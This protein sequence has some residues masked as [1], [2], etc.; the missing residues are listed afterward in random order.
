MDSGKQNGLNNFPIGIRFIQC[1]EETSFME[2]HKFINLMLRYHMLVIDFLHL[3]LMNLLHIVRIL[4]SMIPSYSLKV[5]RT[6][7][8]PWKHKFFNLLCLN[9][10]LSSLLF[11]SHLLSL[12]FLSLHWRCLFLLFVHIPCVPL[13]MVYFEKIA[14]VFRLRYLFWLL[15]NQIVSV[16]YLHCSMCWRNSMYDPLYH[17]MIL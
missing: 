3:C 11:S 12:L 1:V 8:D 7:H 2:N 15:L 13:L 6:Y 9:L 4:E 10:S 16:F 14:C 17:V 5:S